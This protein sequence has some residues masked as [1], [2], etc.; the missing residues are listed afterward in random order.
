M[1]PKNENISHIKYRADID[2][3]RS[4][5]VLSVVAYHAFPFWIPGGFVGVDVF[6]VISGFLISSIIFENLRKGTFSFL[7]FYARRVMRIFPALLLILVASYIF[8]WFNL[9][10]GEFAQLGKHS[11]AGAGFVSN[12]VLY[13]ESGYFD[14]SAELK[15]LLHLWSLGIEEQFYIFWPLILWVLWKLKFDFLTNI[16]IMILFSFSLNIWGITQDSTATFYSPITRFWELLVGCLLALLTT[17][18]GSGFLASKGRLSSWPSGLLFEHVLIVSDQRLSNIISVVGMSFLGLGFVF[19]NKEYNFPG[20]WPLLP[21][22][23]AVFLILAG[24]YAWFNRVVLSNP[25]LVWF[26]L[27]SYPLYLW[28]WPLL[29]FARIVEGGNLSRD[30]RI[31]LVLLSILLAW[32]TFRFVEKPLRSCS[33]SRRSKVTCLVLLMLGVGITGFVTYKYK[34][35]EFRE[36][37]SRSESLYPTSARYSE[38]DYL[39]TFRNYRGDDLSIS[40]KPLVMVIGDS[41]L[42]AWSV[43]LGSHIDIEKYDIVSITY[44]GCSVAL[45][46][47]SLT[48]TADGNQYEESCRLFAKLINSESIKSRVES[49]MLVSHRP[50]EYEEN[51]FRFEILRWLK[52]YSNVTDTYVFG[53]Y[54]QLNPAIYPSC[55]KLMFRKEL[56]SNICLELADYPLLRMSDSKLPFYPPDLEFKYIDIIGLHCGYDRRDCLTSSK[57]VPFMS[58]WNHLNGTF[59][60]ALLNE[61]RLEKA[62]ELEGLGLLK[63]FK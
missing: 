9:L 54:F 34:G 26:G 48:V 12:L 20:F 35:F 1:T 36:F 59:L 18:G 22:I 41:H 7:D 39:A 25:V 16:L 42:S 43:A 5:A 19:I 27:I 2:G 61:I 23:G 49:V 63:Y 14:I 55:E 44:L 13:S 10:G 33:F 4:I 47:A 32:L 6:F 50:F 60:E 46:A 24:P 52:K 53:N 45:E 15:P 57:G 56:D 37:A 30:Y 58:D 28:H 17:I 21:V 11:A 38:R 31:L 51:T 40:Q 62:N 8:G 3:L 29:S